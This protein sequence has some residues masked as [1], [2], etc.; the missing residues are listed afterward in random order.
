[1]ADYLRSHPCVECAESR[2]E[3]LE[4]DHVRGEKKY[5]VASMMSGK[6]SAERVLLEIEK[7][8]VRCIVCHRR[9]TAATLGWTLRSSW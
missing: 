2:L 3:L 5:N 9:K 6:Y 1:V 7:C 8:D 4:F